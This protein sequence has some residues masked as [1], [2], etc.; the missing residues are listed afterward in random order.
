M[1]IYLRKFIP[2]LNPAIKKIIYQVYKI[3]AFIRYACYF[4]KFLFFRG[5]HI[6]VGRDISMLPQVKLSIY[7]KAELDFLEKISFKANSVFW[8]IG[9]NVGLY[10]VIFAKANPTWKIYSFEPNI[11]VHKTFY[12]NISFNNCK[13]IQL[14]PLALSDSKEKLNLRVNRNRPGTST[15][16]SKTRKFNNSEKVEGI[17]GDELFLSR[18]ILAPDFIKIDVE[19]HELKVLN[20]LKVIISNYVP[21]ISIELA[22]NVWKSENEFKLF[23][24]KLN[25]LLLIYN[26]GILITN[27][28]Q[29]KVFI[30]ESENINNSVQTLILVPQKQK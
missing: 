20:G 6:N 1:E 22:V 28:K 19:G 12:K 17:S 27:G 8:D 9:A 23:L 25:E 30:I 13:N 21:I 16:N 4:N 15:L 14:L 18:K 26:S 24:D 3:Y 10:S 2:H 29:K 5:I 11:G 7:E